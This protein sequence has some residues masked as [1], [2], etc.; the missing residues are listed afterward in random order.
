MINRRDKPLWF[1]SFLRTQRQAT[2]RN[3]ESNRRGSKSVGHPIKLQTLHFYARF[4]T[5]SALAKNC[6]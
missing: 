3:P 6:S 2:G 5:A 4:S 1:V